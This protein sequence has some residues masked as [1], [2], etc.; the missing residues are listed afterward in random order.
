MELLLFLEKGLWFGAAAAG[1]AVLFNVPVRTLG[2]IFIM[3][4][5]G[6]LT[7]TAML[8]L[9]VNIIVST[10]AG[11]ILV[12]ILSIPFAHKKHSP[13]PVFAIPAAIPM[14]PGILAYR[15][16]LGLISLAGEINPETYNQILS[17]TVNNGI[18][19]MLILISLAGGV[20]VP[21]LI[22]RKES[23]KEIRFRK[24]SPVK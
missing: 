14:V 13:P 6:G 3:S 9:G 16:M 8:G 12:G 17:E 24:R 15:M 1:F 18:K 11:A 21:L 5:L 22:T 2:P 10:F 20:G 23:A 19:V 4:A 7:K